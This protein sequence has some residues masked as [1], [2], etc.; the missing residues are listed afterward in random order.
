[1][2]DIIG[3]VHGHGDRLEA[4]LSKLGYREQ[5]GV[6]RHPERKLISVG[7]LVDRGPQQRKSVDIIRAMQEADEA[8]VIMGN[9]EFNAVAWVTQ[10]ENGDYLRPHTDKNYTQHK[11]FLQAAEAD[12]DWYR[13]TIEWFKS[14]P[15]YL[16]LPDLRVTHACWHEPS[17][18]IIDLHTDEEGALH[19]SAWQHATR[20]GHELFDAIEIMAKGWEVELPEGYSF[21]DTSKFERRHMRTEWWREDSRNYRDIAI[22]VEPLS[23]L[24]DADIDGAAL[25]GYDHAKPLFLGHYW[26]QG[27]PCLQSKKIACVDWSVAKNG[28]LVAYRFDGEQELRDDKFIWV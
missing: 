16:D 25:P 1:M 19:E 5:Q 23:S 15:F 4:L 3:D 11:A 10:D 22:G 17:K 21:L 8:R 2:Y 24:P 20:K 14:L 7:D 18:R 12:S 26:M 6:W 13:S 27:E 9:H 28:I